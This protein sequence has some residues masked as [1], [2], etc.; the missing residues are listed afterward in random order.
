MRNRPGTVRHPETSKCTE[1]G[2]RLCR[3]HLLL[4]TRDLPDAR[5]EPALP[6]RCA[7]GEHWTHCMRVRTRSGEAKGGGALPA[8]CNAEKGV[9]DMCKAQGQRASKSR[10]SQTGGT[11]GSDVQKSPR[12]AD[13][14]TLIQRMTMGV[15]C[16]QGV[17][18]MFGGIALWA[19]LSK[20]RRH[21]SHNV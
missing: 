20:R 8:H 6:F 14:P 2:L 3:D 4:I 17:P 12:Q 16:A 7:S 5:G 21:T 1:T 15:A 13:P 10:P 18:S 11:A 9:T 19:A